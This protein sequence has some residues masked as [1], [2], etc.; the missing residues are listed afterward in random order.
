[1]SNNKPAAVVTLIIAFAL[2]APFGASAAPIREGGVPQS[3]VGALQV[4]WNRL[5]VVWEKS[6]CDI[7]PDGK[8]ACPGQPKL[9]CGID[10]D[11]KPRC[12]P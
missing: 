10:P 5:A 6:G 11:G 8:P 2:A 3:V 9:G 1:M 4:A 7:G 12:T